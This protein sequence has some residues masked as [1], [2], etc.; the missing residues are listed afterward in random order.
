MNKVILWA[1]AHEMNADQQDELI[2][3]EIGTL[4]FIAPTLDHSLCN[5]QRGDDL[6]QLAQELVEVAE[7]LQADIYQPAGNPL[8]QCTLGRVLERSGS[9]VRVFYADSLRESKDLPQPD[10][11][12]QKVSVFRH[13]GFSPV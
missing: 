9:S 11:S 6:Y 4:Y 3:R 7:T 13:L 12:I 1:S 10:G 2:N 8:F 5:L